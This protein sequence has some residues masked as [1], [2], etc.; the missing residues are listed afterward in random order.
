MGFKI[1]SMVSIF[2]WSIYILSLRRSFLF[3][4]SVKYIIKSNH[5]SYSK[6]LK[7]QLTAHS[8]NVL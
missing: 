2:I 6:R 5:P 4:Y 3:K 1:I 8:T 7:K